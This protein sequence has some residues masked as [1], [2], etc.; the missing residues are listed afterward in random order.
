[1]ILQQ[2]EYTVIAA[3]SS[4]AQGQRWRD[5]ISLGGS[6]LCALAPPTGSRWLGACGRLSAFADKAERAKNV[7][8]AAERPQT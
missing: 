5:P 6:I 2:I 3:M 7:P 1:V 8:H 4:A